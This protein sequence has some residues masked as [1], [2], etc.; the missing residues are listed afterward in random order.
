MIAGTSV[1]LDDSGAEFVG[2]DRFVFPF[3]TLTIVLASVVV[4]VRTVN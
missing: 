3:L 2:A 4:D 1:T